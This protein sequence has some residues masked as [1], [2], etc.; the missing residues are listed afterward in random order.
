MKP[1]EIRRL[2]RKLSRRRHRHLKRMI[3]WKQWP[4]IHRDELADAQRRMEDLTKEIA[5]LL[6]KL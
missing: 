3:Y 4:S 5:T 2:I 6:A 1:S